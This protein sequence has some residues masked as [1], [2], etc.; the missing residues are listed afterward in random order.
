M[1][2]KFSQKFRKLTS[3]NNRNSCYNELLCVSLIFKNNTISYY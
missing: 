1:I 2:T 3:R